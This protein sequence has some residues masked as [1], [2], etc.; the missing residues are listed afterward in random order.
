M[1]ER[2]CRADEQR[3]KAYYQTLL[4]TGAPFETGSSSPYAPLTGAEFAQ[5]LHEI[6][7]KSKSSPMAQVADIF[8]WPLVL[9]AYGDD[10]RASVTL[11][12]AGRFIE[13][14]LMPDE[15]AV[16]GSKRS[17]FELVDLHKRIH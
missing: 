8:L 16:Y 7:F 9:A 4:T 3:L 17:C 11:R 1:P 5:T 10:N 14:R 2:S 6:R 13:S 15:I 12:E